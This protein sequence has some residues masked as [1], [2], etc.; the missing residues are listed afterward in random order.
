MAI[1]LQKMSL[2]MRKCGRVH[3]TEWYGCGYL[4]ETNN[5]FTDFF[6]LAVLQQKLTKLQLPHACLFIH[7]LL[8][9]YTLLVSVHQA[10]LEG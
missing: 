2:K 8:Q 5:L 9:A 7:H 6:P 1:P 4:N 10:V 3:I